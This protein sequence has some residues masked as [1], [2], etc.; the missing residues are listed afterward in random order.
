SHEQS[1]RSLTRSKQLSARGSRGRLPVV[2]RRATTRRYCRAMRGACVVLVIA[3]LLA[4]LRGLAAPASE[5]SEPDNSRPIVSAPAREF[6][7]KQLGIEA[8]YTRG[9]EESGAAPLYWQ[10]YEGR[11]RNLIDPAAF[12]SKAGRE[13]LAS[14]Y[15]RWTVLKPLLVIGGLGA[16]VGA[17]FTL[18]TRPVAYAL[19][20]GGLVMF[21][22]GYVAN[23]HPVGHKEAAT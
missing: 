15:T 14:S 5:S 9:G 7:R 10:P 1:S 18:K 13:D 4:P 3:V 20:G 23:P 6:S 19:A 17:L 2:D 12:Y 21:F 22:V 11:G 8:F 16:M